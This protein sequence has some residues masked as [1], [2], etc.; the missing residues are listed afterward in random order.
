MARDGFADPA[1]LPGHTWEVAVPP[2]YQPDTTTV[3]ICLSGMQVALSAH[4]FPL[5]LPLPCGP[6][7]QL[8]GHTATPLHLPTNLRSAFPGEKRS[9]FVAVP[10]PDSPWSQLLI[11]AKSLAQTHGTVVTVK[12]EDVSIGKTEKKLSTLAA[13]E[14]GNRRTRSPCHPS[15][16]SSGHPSAPGRVSGQHSEFL[17]LNEM[18]NGE[19]LLQ[20]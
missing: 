8:W 13:K 12:M 4:V 16:A 2:L 3:L 10:T 14:A 20:A 18:G 9:S 5:V 15:P 19:I 1:G 11:L 17:R 7:A 6:A